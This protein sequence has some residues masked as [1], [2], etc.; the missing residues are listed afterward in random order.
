MSSAPPF[1]PIHP[2]GWL[3][4]PDTLGRIA[5]HPASIP[6]RFPGHQVIALTTQAPNSLLP[7]NP[8]PTDLHTGSRKDSPPILNS[9]HQHTQVHC[10][11]T[12]NLP[13]SARANWRHHHVTS[14][15]HSPLSEQA[16]FIAI[17]QNKFGFSG[18]LN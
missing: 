16:S 11:H 13:S 3:G 7:M 14:W 6:W 9:M 4:R 12:L 10:S 8:P 2:P 1:T 18:N 15:S 17:R 5:L